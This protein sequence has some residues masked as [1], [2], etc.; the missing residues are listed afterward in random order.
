MEIC[1]VQLKDLKCNHYDTFIIW[2]LKQ[3]GP[4][5][6]QL[7]KSFSDLFWSIMIIS[8][9]LFSSGIYC[10]KST[11]IGIQLGLECLVFLDFSLQVGWILKTEDSVFFV[12]KSPFSHRPPRLHSRNCTLN[13][14]H[15]SP[16]DDV[17]W[18]LSLHVKWQCYPILLR[19]LIVSTT[20][21]FN[22]V[23]QNWNLPT[24]LLTDYWDSHLYVSVCPSNTDSHLVR[25]IASNF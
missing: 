12:T 24:H 25:F 19:R 20:S 9:Q 7:I 13:I 16:W 11:L 2:S 14:L 8:N 1:M 4:Q 6:M 17:R 18:R 10:I 3:I 15:W 22:L 5:L 21:I 23:L